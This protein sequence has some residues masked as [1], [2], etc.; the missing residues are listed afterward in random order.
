[1]NASETTEPRILDTY[2]LV[3]AFSLLLLLPGLWIA[4]GSGYKSYSLIYLAGIAAPFVL[5][6]SAVF[7][8]DSAE[9][10]KTRLVRI[11]VLLP[12]VTMTGVAGM[13]GVSIILVP[14]SP[15]IRVDNFSILSAV[16]MV[17]LALVVAPLALALARRLRKGLNGLDVLHVVVLIA[18]LTLTGVVAFVLNRYDGMLEE[19]LRKDMLIYLVGALTWYLPSFGLSAGIWRRRGLV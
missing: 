4:S 9:P 17:A 10:V 14:V 5:G 8:S 15:W 19:Y 13:F 1:M 11:A 3:Y 12:L 16:S 6:L 18:A 2:A 7:L